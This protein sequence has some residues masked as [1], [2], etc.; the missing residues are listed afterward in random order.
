[1]KQRLDKTNDWAKATPRV[2]LHSNLPLI[3]WMHPI[4]GRLPGTMPVDIDNWLLKD[5]VFSQQMAYRDH[6]IE[7]RRDVVFHCLE[8]AMDA[9]TEL[10]DTLAN[11]LPNI[12]GY[13]YKG[14][15]LTRPD[16][17][18]I[19]LSNDHPL[20]VASRLVQEDLCLL[21]QDGS[22][23]ILVGG[24]VCFPARWTL[25]QKMERS[26]TSLHHPVDAYDENLA[27][28]VER[29]FSH[30][31]PEQPLMRGNYLIFTDPEL[32]QPAEE[33]EG[34]PHPSLAP[35]YV[36]VERQT[37]RRLPET[38]MLVFAIHTCLVRAS[39]L[40]EPEYQQLLQKRP[41]LA[42]PSGRDCE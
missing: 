29:M 41:H 23:H 26:L 21:Q 28:R 25:S 20:I 36:R 22:A 39:D 19:D 14:G 8:G 33:G 10:R 6:L 3:P 7:R 18:T 24:T 17:I 30:I 15:Q 37:L 32:H 31:R 34:R 11:E 12:A 2:I 27:R 42:I 1:M 16:G 13:A 38:G 5:E 4:M 40:S 9:A 35:R